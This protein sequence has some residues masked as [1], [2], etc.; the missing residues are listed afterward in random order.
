MT[1]WEDPPR[2][3]DDLPPQVGV[4]LGGPFDSAEFDL[5]E[6]IVTEYQ[7]P[8]GRLVDWQD[9]KRGQEVLAIMHTYQM[10]RCLGWPSRD[11]HGRIQYRWVASEEIR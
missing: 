10:D 8:E 2:W 4:L 5:L 11:D 6:G 7:V 9:F 1:A 3:P